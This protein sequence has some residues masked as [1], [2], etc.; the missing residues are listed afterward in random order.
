MSAQ[1]AE[2]N[3]PAAAA[4]PVRIERAG[5]VAFIVI[6]NPPV[7]AGSLAV[8]QGIVAAIAELAADAEL[9]AGVLIGAG[10]T[11]VAGSDLREFSA[12]LGDPQMPAVI[13]A[14]EACPK[15]VVAAIHG[16]ALGGGY[17][18]A[19]GCDGRVARTDA[20]V[21]LPEGT[22]GIIPGAGGTVRLT[23]LT[24]AATALEIVST[25]RRVTAPEARTLGLVDAV[26]Q[27]LRA[28]AAAF[29]LSLNGAKRRLR[30]RP[31][32]PVDPAAFEKVA[33]A[34]LRRGR[35]RPYAQEQVAAF[36]RAAG[37]PFDVAL[38]EERAVFQRLR[39]SEEAAALRY[40]FFAERDAARIDG[41]AG[42]KPRPVSTVG[43]VGAGTMGSGIAA[44][45]LGAG[46]PVTLIDSTPEAL[47][48]A[49]QRI[50][51]F[52]AKAA[53]PATL[54][55]STDLAD[56]AGCDLV[57]EAVFED[58]SVKQELLC[59]LDGILR[60]D[61][62]LASNTS[63]LDLDALAAATARPERVVGLHFFAPAHVMKLLEVVRGA[64]T[65]PDV[66]TTALKLGGKLG[67]VAVVARVGEGFIGNRIYNAYRAQCEE[68]L[69]AG[70]LPE[71]IDAAIEAFGFAMG[72][73]SVSDLSGLDIAW[74]N[75]RRKQAETC[76]RSA[77]PVLEWLVELGRLGRKTGAGWYR[78]EGGRRVPDPA[79]AALV[80]KARAERGSRPRPL[81]REEIQRRAMA[82]I[83]DEARLV[84][85]NNIAARASDIDLVLTYGYGF[86][87]H[88]GGPLYWAAGQ[89]ETARDGLMPAL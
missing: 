77:V 58:M 89:A 62:I 30:D 32:M 16:A 56:L 1:S 48:A 51:G 14:I 84:L 43:I 79:V 2:T 88:R 55:T 85:E 59:K 40:L 50:D 65:S 83:V 80:E 69:L 21:G 71:E 23:R 74:A 78:Y 6:D 53:K 7:N 35:N 72:P 8:R 31:A 29:A 76:D 34:A 39:Q 28:E 86:P 66:L 4:L 81:S 22:F 41:L 36:R 63:Y 11:F 44:A 70:A 20:V 45:F 38:A 15:P 75:R 10:S 60:P 68:M 67:K 49:R 46:L 5:P 73:F 25:C 61:A 17:E 47:D 19:L 18:I 87:K 24:D 33:E 3:P 42:V 12:P 82:A 52:L 13:A 9:T 37:E 26:V 64:R 57:L 27:D 54:T